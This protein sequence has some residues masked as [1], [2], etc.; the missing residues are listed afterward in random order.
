VKFNTDASE[1]ALASRLPKPTTTPSVV[2]DPDA[3]LPL[4]HPSGSPTK[5]SDYINSDRPQLGL[6]IVSF[7]DK[8][9]VTMYW[10]HTLMD[11]MG[12]KALLDAW[13]LILQGREEEVKIPHGADFDPLEHLG[14]NPTELHKLE[15]KRIGIWGLVGYALGQ[16]PNLWRKRE[17]RMVC[18]PPSFLE[19]LRE[20]AIQELTAEGEENPFLSEGDVLCAWWTRLATSHLPSSNQTVVLNNAY[21][22]RK[23]LQN[24]LLP[25]GS[26]YVSNAIGFLNAVLSLQ[27]VVEKPLSYTASRIRQAIQ[28]LGTREQVEAFYALLRESSTKL[29]LFFGDR[30]MHMITYSNWTKAKL[31]N[32]DFSAAI[33]GGGEGGVAKPVYIQNN[34]LGLTLPNG[35]PIIGK[36]NE[37]NY[38]LSGYM[39]EGVWEGIQELLEKE[40]I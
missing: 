17:T 2:G 36:D 11:A 4:M 7:E 8:T 28:E 39:S 19:K 30:N 10:M 37:G 14:R 40:E 3:F 21:D 9:L 27:D 5:L 16:L 35:F 6:H 23:P 31:F 29:P 38:W 12:K 15:E 34:Q 1:H 22:I 33:V 24:D 18:V 26:V 20:G 13:I 32:V 25:E